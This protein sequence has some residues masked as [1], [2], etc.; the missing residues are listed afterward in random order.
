MSLAV[1]VVYATA[2]RCWRWAVRL[3]S[4]ATVADALAAAA[5]EEAGLDR[6][7]LPAAVGV[8]GREAD[9]GRRLERHDRVE[10]YRPLRCD[11]KRVRRA[12]AERERALRGK[13][14]QG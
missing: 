7:D 5:L 10:I 3:E 4:G 2:E 12:R 8:F 6:A 13:H 1:E 9:L 11:P 14:R